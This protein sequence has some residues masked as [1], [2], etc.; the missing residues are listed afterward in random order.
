MANAIRRISVQ[1]GHDVGDHTLVC[2][3]G[4]GGQ[5]A[6]AVADRLGIPRVLVH[7]QAGRAVGR[8][9]RPGRDPPRGQPRRRD[10]TRRRRRGAGRGVRGP[11]DRGRRRA[12]G[13]G[14]RRRERRGWS[15]GWLVRAAGSDT[16]LVIDAGE[17]ADVRA[18]FVVAHRNRF[19][20][21]DDDRFAGGRGGTGRGH[22]SHADGRPR[23]PDD[24]SSPTDR[25][26]DPRCSSWRVE[27]RAPFVDRSR[28]AAGRA[29]AGPGRRSSR[30]TPRRSSTRDGRR[31]CSAAG[32][33]LIERSR[34]PAPEPA[35][36]APMSIPSSS[37]SSTTSS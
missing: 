8:R 31:P 4:A 15:G 14:A 13:P 36:W 25:H 30:R 22:R 20:F 10:G 24:G 21:V 3:G 33:L 2:F 35:M 16:A 34:L 37:R 27:R 11:R 6:C 26:P 9:H 29:V 32:D 5:H 7:P 1:R 19:G 12:G 23:G 17:P 18:A 28:L